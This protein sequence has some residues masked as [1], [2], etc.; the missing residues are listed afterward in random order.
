L[1]LIAVFSLVVVSLDRIVSNKAIAY[2]DEKAKIFATE[3]AK[4]IDDGF[5]NAQD[6]IQVVETYFCQID[7]SALPAVSDWIQ[8]ILK[9]THYT[10]CIW[11]SFEK[12]ALIPNERFSRD[13]VK[14]GDSIVIIH[15]LDDDILD[16]PEVAPWYYYPFTTGKMWF[17]SADYYDYQLGFGGKYT[18]TVS[19]PITRR[20]DGQI[21]GVVGV[22][23]LYEKT[24]KFIDD[25]QIKNKQ[26]LMLLTPDGEIVYSA[27]S[28]LV[29]KSVFDLPFKNRDLVRE[30]LTKDGVSKIRVISPFF[31]VKSNIYLYP[32]SSIGDKSSQLYLYVDLHPGG[33][34]SDAENTTRL[35]ILISVIGLLLFAFLLFFMV[36]HILKPIKRL[37]ESANTIIDGK[38]D[39]TIDSVLNAE[40]AKHKNGTKNEVHILLTAMK[41]MNEHL[42]QTK[43]IE[44][45][46]KAKS[47]FLAK[48]SHEI[49]TPMNA[50]AGMTELALREE[51]PAAAKEHLF[52]I[53]QATSNLL[54]IINDILDL[55]KIE[56]GKLKIVPSAYHLSSLVNDVISIIRM[57][58]L[59]SKVR[60]TV[61]LDC[62]IPNALLG[63]EIRVRQILLNILGNA[64]KYTAKG[65]ISFTVNGNVTDE[66]TVLL[67][68]DVSDTGKGIR[69]E[70]MGKLFGD[71][72]QVDT[73][74]NRGI[75]GTGLG[76]AITKNLVAAMGGKIGVVS[77]YGKG[78]TFTVTLPQKILMPD[79]LASVDNPE[80]KSVLVY[81]RREVYS[82]SIIRTIDNLGVACAYARNDEEFR[83]K[84]QSKDYAFVF[85][86][87]NMYERARRILSEIN[88]KAQVVLLTN[89]GDTA[90]DR[91]FRVIA[92]PA[93]SVSVANVINNV[94]GNFSYDA[95]DDALVRFSAPE[96][97]VL[98]VDDIK[99]NLKVAEG[100]LLPYKMQIDLCRS[101]ILALDMVENNH[102]DLILM[103]H[104]MPEMDGIEAA[105]LIRVS[106]GD[107]AGVPIIALTANAVS[108]MRE[109]FLEN[110]FND[111]LSKPIDT[112]KLNAILEKWIPKEKKVA[113]VIKTNTDR[114]AVSGIMLD[115]VDVNIGITRTGG[116]SAG[117]LRALAA[118]CKDGWEKIDEIRKCSETGDNNL[119]ATLAHGLK[120]AAAN[121]GAVGLS[122][123]AKELEMAASRS[124]K[125]FIETHTDSLLKELEA[126]L[127]NI[128]KVISERKKRLSG[129]TTVDTRLL[130]ATLA[131]LRAALDELNPK[132]IKTAVE[133]LRQFENTAEETGGIVE[134]ILQNV[135][136]GEYE[137]AVSLIDS[138]QK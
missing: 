55:A 71:F 83:G 65:Y 70:D 128:G 57:K 48:M 110:G 95:N 91:G 6:M 122:E 116:N 120:S 18:G 1:P 86:E 105:K 43:K 106:G 47:D 90:A 78:S 133:A 84:L 19:M 26:I 45:V 38:N 56:S 41:N 46:S 20:G 66:D 137:E 13:F 59:D 72:I 136:I 81:E 21:I 61:N 107:N 4:Q 87:S 123:A 132:A 54:S 64:V 53:K 5:K 22:D 58:T 34:F 7:S 134:E 33:F 98:I 129:E 109:M 32:V 92:M 17:E 50:I 77:E 30:R 103:D 36:K 82:D 11:V 40:L 52:T 108:G 74:S 102:Y 12:D 121:I 75:E 114:K 3:I 119:Y 67:T 93:H 89:F 42:R 130:T 25:R 104:M 126:L 69:Q 60:L 79:T 14:T 51:M 94:S 85:I 117:Y 15:D 131:S 49:R 100:L 16:D 113:A 138:M 37:T 62:K 31:G 118:F 111:F 97:K 63:D 29:T 28:S 23:M 8:S 35:V 73:L 80:G 124:D 24:F 9:A 27:D 39:L 99:T 44:A 135:L 96:A 10:H 88:S 125:T 112:V 115:G 68:I 101:G 76:L 127:L 2:A